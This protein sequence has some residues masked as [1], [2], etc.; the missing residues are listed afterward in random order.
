MGEFSECR[1]HGCHPQAKL[2]GGLKPVL[3]P[4]E[5]PA[6][7]TPSQG[8]RKDVYL[9]WRGQY[10]GDCYFLSLEFCKSRNSGNPASRGEK[11]GRTE[12]QPRRENV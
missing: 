10:I 6:D 3:A 4:L 2:G 7:N 8:G 5:Q 12:D 11:R 9:S 1:D